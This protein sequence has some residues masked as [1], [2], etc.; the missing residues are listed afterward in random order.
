MVAC[1]QCVVH[2]NSRKAIA[3]CQV[4]NLP[5]SIVNRLILLVVVATKGAGGVALPLTMW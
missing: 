4:A 1:R 2:P 3:L 5:S